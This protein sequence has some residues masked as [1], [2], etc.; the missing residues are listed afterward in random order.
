MTPRNRTRRDR[1]LPLAAVGL[2][3]AGCI[4]ST[5]GCDPGWTSTEDQISFSDPTLV[6]GAEG[7]FENQGPVLV[8]T[9]SCPLIDCVRPQVE[10]EDDPPLDLCPQNGDELTSNYALLECFQMSVNVLGAQLEGTCLT[11][12]EPNIGVGWV[13]LATTC[14]AQIGGF[15]PVDD[16]VF[17]QVVG[18][19]G[20]IAWF[21]PSADLYANDNMRPG[22]GKSFPTD[23]TRKLGEPIKLMGG[24]EVRLPITL[25]DATTHREVAWQPRLPDLHGGGENATVE[26]EVVEGEPPQLALTSDGSLLITIATGSRANLELVTPVA[27]FSLGEVRGVAEDD[28]DSLEVV[29]GYAPPESSLPDAPAGARAILRDKDGDPIYGAR[30]HWEVI[31]GFLGLGR[32]GSIDGE[33]DPEVADCDYIALAGDCYENPYRPN[34]VKASL[35]ARWGELEASDTLEWTIVPGSGGNFWNQFVDVFGGSSKSEGQQTAYVCE[36]PGAVSGCGC[37]TRDRGGG[38][39]WMLIGLIALRRRMA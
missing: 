29:V 2:A 8:G 5:R 1:W 6:I 32:T 35:V 33:P 24:S 16:D 23:A 27:S 39:L 12:A 11:F 26:A 20:L 4:D 37:D 25:E 31:E 13:F 15:A 21:K 30:V 9:V 7:F 38:A 22:P 17:F 10:D 36:G 34:V 19:E 14:D 3:L 18:P 28:V